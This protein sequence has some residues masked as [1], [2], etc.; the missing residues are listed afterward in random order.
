MIAM[1]ERDDEVQH[2][3]IPAPME[4]RS[5][6][7]R[8][9][10]GSPSSFVTP[11]GWKMYGPVGGMVFYQGQVFVSHRDEDDRGVITA[12]DYKGTTRRSSE[13]SPPRGI[14]A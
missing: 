10:D 2:L 5:Q 4:A 1:G 9:A 12:L 14:M 7:T 13:T 11:G 6:S 8:R 3:R